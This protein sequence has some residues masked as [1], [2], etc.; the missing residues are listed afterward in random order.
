VGVP[1]LLQEGTELLR[2]EGRS[3]SNAQW[4]PERRAVSPSPLVRLTRPPGLGFI[5][6]T[7]LMLVLFVAVGLVE[8]AG[9]AGVP[10]QRLS[11][12][13]TESHRAV[14]RPAAGPPGTS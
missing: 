3:K 2:I 11:R 1:Q 9:Q 10:R 14:S 13:L 6:L 12:P 8:V 4:R 5:G 7:I